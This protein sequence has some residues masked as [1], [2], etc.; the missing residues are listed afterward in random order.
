VHGHPGGLDDDDEVRVLAAH[1][2]REARV[3]LG[4]A[5]ARGALARLERADLERARRRDTLAPAERAAVEDDAALVDEEQ[6]ETLAKVGQLAD[7]D[8]LDALPGV[9]AAEAHARR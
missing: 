4:R 1:V 9:F 8:L 6:D 7:E 2:E 3:R 5:R